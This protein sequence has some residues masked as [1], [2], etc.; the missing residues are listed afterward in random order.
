MTENEAEFE[1]PRAVAL[2]WGVAASPQRGPKREL[3]IERIVET[4]VAIADTDGLGA[5]S[6]SSIATRLGF[7]TMSLYRYVTAKDD[8]FVL[9]QE[10]G[11]GLPSTAVADAPD[12]R[13]GLSAWRRASL[14]AYAAHPWLIDIP[15]TGTPSTPNNL[16]W[17]DAA[18]ATLADTPL[19]PSE[20]LGVILLVTGH[21]RWEGSVMKGYAQ[22]MGDGVTISDRDRADALVL[23]TLVTADAFPALHPIIAA[24]VFEAEDDPFSFGFELLLDGIQTFIDSGKAGAPVPPPTAA[25]P[26][27]YP[28][29][30]AVRLARQARR[31]AETKLR[32]AQRKEREALSRAAERA[33]KA[34]EKAAK[35]R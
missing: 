10:Y 14:A 20:R 8:L 3:S 21:A 35:G 7:T 34:A 29:D 25:E 4:A 15:I 17:M 23:S 18:L 22:S 33:A 5:V 26:A 9:M 31:E 1:L 30:P 13:A 19:S 32:E 12:W 27:D 16:A 24:G 6:M 28:K 11:T 2:A